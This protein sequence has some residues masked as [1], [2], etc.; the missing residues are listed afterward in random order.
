MFP[1]SKV[2][3]NTDSLEKGEFGEDIVLDSSRIRKR[4]EVETVLT[5]R[6]I[7]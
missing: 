4:L 3:G 5:L 2:I 7:G 1:R 6:E